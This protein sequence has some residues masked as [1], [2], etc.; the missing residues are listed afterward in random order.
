MLTVQIQTVYSTAYLCFFTSTLPHCL[1]QKVHCQTTYVPTASIAEANKEV[2][3]AAAEA[4]EPQKKG[5]YIKVTPEYKAKVVKFVSNNGNSY[6]KR[7][8]VVVY[9]MPA[10]QHFSNKT[11][12]N[13]LVCDIPLS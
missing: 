13:F 8:V 11:G 7:I 4:K 5:P 10:V 9:I 6:N 12:P 2:L 1:I 3:K